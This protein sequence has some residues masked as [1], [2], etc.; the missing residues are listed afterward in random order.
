MQYESLLAA[1]GLERSDWHQAGSKWQS[2]PKERRAL[3]DS[4]HACA[5]T[6]GSA[7]LWFNQPAVK[8]AGISV[9]RPGAAQN[10]PFMSSTG[11]LSI[12]R[13]W[14]GGHG[15]SADVVRKRFPY[16]TPAV[17]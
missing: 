17:W 2:L 11:I 6:G 13:L 14:H 8:D 5:R 10:L 12:R 1:A 4:C 7:T 16:P 15:A 3:L 9:S